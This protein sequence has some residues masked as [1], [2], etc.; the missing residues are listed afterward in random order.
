MVVYVLNDEIAN[1][2][3]DEDFQIVEYKNG[4]IKKYKL[5]KHMPLIIVAAIL[6][7]SSFKVELQDDR[8][9]ILNNIPNLLKKL[10]KVDLINGYN[11]FVLC[12]NIFI[13]DELEKDALTSS[14]ETLKELL[15]KDSILAD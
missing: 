3:Y 12:K 8:T 5:L 13:K 1:I 2:T 7:K 15:N 11:K 4:K 9:F 6:Y 10:N 14:D